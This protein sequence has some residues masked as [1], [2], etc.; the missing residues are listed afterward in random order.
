MKKQF[1]YDEKELTKFEPEFHQKY[2]YN[3]PYLFAI[4]GKIVIVGECQVTA[5]DVYLE[6][7]VSLEERQGHGKL[8]IE[9]LMVDLGVKEIYGESVLEA[10]HFWRK[11]GAVF[12]QSSEEHFI[13]NEHDNDFTFAE[14]FLIPFNIYNKTA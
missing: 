2:C 9:H 6:H 13:A 12:N 5:E 4:D 10:Y 14:D 1:V 7:V 11:V 3:R 8:F